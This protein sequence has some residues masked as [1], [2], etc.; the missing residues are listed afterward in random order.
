MYMG[1]E[2]GELDS[3]KDTKTVLPALKTL[4]IRGA[5]NYDYFLSD[6][7]PLLTAAPNLETLY[8]LDCNGVKYS[9]TTYAS[10]ANEDMWIKNLAVNKIH[11]LVF[12][13]SPAVFEKLVKQCVQLEDLE[14]YIYSWEN[15]PDIMQAIFPIKER[16]RRLCFGYLQPPAPS[17]ESRLLDNNYT[18]I[19]SLQEFTH[20][21]ELVIDQALLYR[22]SDTSK[23]S[24]LVSLLPRSIRRIHLTYVYKSIYEDL[25]SLAR[26]REAPGSFP[27]L[28]SIKIGL[29]SP[30]APERAAEIEC[31]K[32][33]EST[34]ISTGVQVSWA[35]DLKGPYLYTAIPGGAPGLTVAHVPASSWKYGSNTDVSKMAHE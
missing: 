6:I 31:M 21:E 20:L 18:T 25:M 12:D 33:V 19:T 15:C 35:E 5:N 11:K 2:L 1:E 17:Y 9:Q 10:M 8:A 7:H 13:V 30:I 34:F 32:T 29:L 14:Y 4:A 24:R 23:D 27:N 3:F 26:A 22:K 16:L 28:Q